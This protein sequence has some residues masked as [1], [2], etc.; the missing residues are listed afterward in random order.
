M[1]ASSR[2]TLL[3]AQPGTVLPVGFPVTGLIVW[4]PHLTVSPMRAGLSQ[5]WSMA[6][7]SVPSTG[8]GT[9]EHEEIVG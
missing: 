5:P 7:S 2:R 3:R 9:D 8:A 1:F 4:L 6:V